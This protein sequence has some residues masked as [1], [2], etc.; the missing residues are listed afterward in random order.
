MEHDSMDGLAQLVLRKLCRIANSLRMRPTAIMWPKAITCMRPKAVMRPKILLRYDAA[1][2]DTS[3]KILVRKILVRY[4]SDTG[5]ILVR[6][7]DTDKILVRYWYNASNVM[8]ESI[9]QTRMWTRH[10]PGHE[11]GSCRLWLPWGDEGRILH[12]GRGQEVHKSPH[13]ASTTFQLFTW[14]GSLS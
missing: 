7:R 3:G 2:K 1:K 4:C 9:K 11:K 10:S 6:E 5:E 8:C 12:H 14:R 13:S